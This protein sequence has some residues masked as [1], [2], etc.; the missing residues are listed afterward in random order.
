[1]KLLSSIALA[2]ITL[3]NSHSITMAQT[4]FASAMQDGQHILLIRHADAPGF[5][6]PKGY[7]MTD[8]STQRNLGELGKRQ[9]QAIGEWLSKQGIRQAKVYISPWCRC[10]DTATLLNQGSVTKEA[11]LGSF[12]DDMSQAK[13]QTEA[14]RRL[15]QVERGKHPHS[16]IIMVTHHVNIE[17]FTGKVINSGD[18]IL[19]K[20]DPT[21]KAISHTLYPSP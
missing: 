21:G 3:L 12:F 14:L 5:G 19:V 9:A 4:P 13:K 10:L 15:I 11:A 18:M 1:M 16:P 8:C 20:V 17:S 7:Q 2:L 6:D